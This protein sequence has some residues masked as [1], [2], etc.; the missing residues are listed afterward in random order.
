MIECRHVW[1]LRRHLW[2]GVMVYCRRCRDTTLTEGEAEAMLNEHA[3]LEAENTALKRENER[4]RKY[5]LLTG[6]E[7]ETE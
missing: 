3:Q 4:F 2:H 7:D 1:R 6:G 5:G